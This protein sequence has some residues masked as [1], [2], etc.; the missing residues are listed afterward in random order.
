[1][2]E[3]TSPSKDNQSQQT[4]PP[5]NQGQ[6]KTLKIIL[7]VLAV[8]VVLGVLGTMLL[9]FIG[10]KVGKE[11]FEQ[12]T[13]TQIETDGDNV[14]IESDDGSLQVGG[15]ELAD[16]FP[17]EVPLYDPATVT[18]SSSYSAG[19]NKV[20]SVRLTSDDE[21]DDIYAFYDDEF[22]DGWEVQSTSSR[23][24]TRTISALRQ[25]EITRVNVVI[26]AGDQSELTLSVTRLENNE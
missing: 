3:N 20:W 9:G 22:S 24:D 26:E 11:I 18:S 2:A 14:S 5:P 13:N 23:N 7:I 17:S 10:A 16:D 8:L 1:M 4:P 6:K 21:V 12:S 19:E 15:A 25:D